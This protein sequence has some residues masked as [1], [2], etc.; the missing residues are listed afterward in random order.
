M[1]RILKAFLNPIL[2]CD[3]VWQLENDFS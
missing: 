3:Q 1:S 2:S